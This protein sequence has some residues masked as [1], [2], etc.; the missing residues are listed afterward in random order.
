MF[1]ID[2]KWND[3][4]AKVL[5]NYLLN[6]SFVSG[7]CHECKI[8]TAFNYIRCLTCKHKLCGNCDHEKHYKQPFHVRM[9]DTEDER[10]PLVSMDFV[11]YPNGEIYQDGNLN[12]FF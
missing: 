12:S 2:D 1:D 3:E 9:L 7:Q 6:N 10:K 4:R 5:N 8:E 11:S